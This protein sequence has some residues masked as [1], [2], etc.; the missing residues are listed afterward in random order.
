MNKFITMNLFKN[1]KVDG[2][3]LQGRGGTKI[4]NR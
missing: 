1:V 2:H 4:A 3:G